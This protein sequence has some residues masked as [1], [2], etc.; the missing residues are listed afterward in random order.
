MLGQKRGAS[1]AVPAA[2]QR[3]E[4]TTEKFR[5]E[6]H[7]AKIRFRQKVSQLAAIFNPF[8]HLL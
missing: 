2:K 5:P 8:C 7:M 6:I 4:A 1:L 3:L